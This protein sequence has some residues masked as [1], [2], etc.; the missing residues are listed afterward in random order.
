MPVGQR[1]PGLRRRARTLWFPRPALFDVAP[2]INILMIVGFCVYYFKSVDNAVVVVDALFIMIMIGERGGL[3][4]F[5][6]RRMLIYIC[7]YVFIYIYM[8]ILSYACMYMCV[9]R[10][11]V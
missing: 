1:W 9:T 6:K 8:N 2:C 11:Y 5:A 7:E 4:A 10:V 3:L